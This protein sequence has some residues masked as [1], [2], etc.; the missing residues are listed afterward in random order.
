M[1]REKFKTLT[2]QMFYVLLIL[3]DEHNGAQ[4][5]RAIHDLTRGR[6]II[7]PGTLYALL[8]EFSESMLIRITGQDSNQKTYQLTEK[9]KKLLDQEYQR[10]TEQI[11]DYMMCF[12]K[13]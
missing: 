7:G 1:A 6:V 10:L 3:K 8:G 2:E 12:S 4:I 5:T 13:G 11:D 9:G